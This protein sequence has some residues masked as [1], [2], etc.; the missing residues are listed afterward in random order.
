MEKWSKQ[1][2]HTTRGIF[3]V[4]TKGKGQPLC[5]THHYSEYNDTGDYFAD[6]F[7]DQHKVYLVNLREAGNS[8]KASEPYELSLL[9]TVFDLEAIREALKLPSWSFAGHSI[10]GVIGVMYG[11]HF[12]NKLNANILV[13][14]AARDYATLSS[15]CIYNPAHPDF[16]YMQELIETLKCPDLSEE[17]RKEKSIER[18]QLSLH[19]P[20]THHQLFNKNIHK[21]M[22]VPRLNFFNRE[23]QIF[24]VTKKLHLS[25]VKT[26]I[27]C[28]KHDVQCPLEFSM[29]MY[30]LL[31]QAELVVFQESNH[32]PFLEEKELFIREVDRFMKS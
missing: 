11:I 27:A 24:D 30:D 31:P 17:M 15:T 3:E 7:T 14:A 25:S 32:Y 6:I 8:V 16:E 1:M 29:E 12:S 4:F 21:R 5:V 2:V 18:T 28:G 22:A 23:L 26:F 20:E 9:E 13:G 19:D 10:G